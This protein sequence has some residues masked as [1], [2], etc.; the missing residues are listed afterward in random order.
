MLP[1]GIA[2]P[3][4]TSTCSPETTVSPC[5]SRCG[6][7]I[8]ASSPSSY[9]ISAM[10]PV[11]LGSYSM[12][13]TLAGT[14]NLRRLK[15]VLAVGFLVTAAA[16]PRGDAAFVVAP[17]ARNLALGQR[18]HRRAVM[19]AGTIDQHE[20]TLARRDRVVGLKRHRFPPYRPVV[21]SIL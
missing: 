1:T 7:R 8:Y 2:L 12:R 21:T 10:K 15:I 18:L 4:F 13:S 14:S 16:K 3:G 5:A 6:A 17:A 9:L 20:L 19:E 11:R